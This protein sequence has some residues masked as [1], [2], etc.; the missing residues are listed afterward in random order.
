MDSNIAMDVEES[1]KGS[2]IDIEE[3]RSIKPEDLLI[4]DLYETKDIDVYQ[5][6][7]LDSELAAKDI[8]QDVFDDAFDI[9]ME[10][11]YWS[12]VP[13][14]ISKSIVDLAEVSLEG[15]Y[16]KTDEDDMDDLKAA[17]ACDNHAV[18]YT[19]LIPGR[20]RFRWIVM[21]GRG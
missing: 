19:S 15:L 13:S 10:K 18:I 9:I 3:E 2:D 11:Y 1:L 16:K 8:I 5:K 14:N 7:L 12:K 6:L 17:F 20:R 4:Y 21:E